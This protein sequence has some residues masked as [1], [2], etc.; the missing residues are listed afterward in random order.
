MRTETTA[1]RYLWLNHRIVVKGVQITSPSFI[2]IL[3]GCDFC[4]HPCTDQG[5]FTLSVVS[6][7]N[8][9]WVRSWLVSLTAFLSKF[10]NQL[11][12]RALCQCVCT[13]EAFFKHLSRPSVQL[14]LEIMLDNKKPSCLFKNHFCSSHKFTSTQCINSFGTAVH[15]LIYVVLARTN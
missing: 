12:Y 3:K 7:N 9:W 11:R 14:Y 1:Q 4:Q 15:W 6:S 8:C 5:A 2:C 13:Q 10:H